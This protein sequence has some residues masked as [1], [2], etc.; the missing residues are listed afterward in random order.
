MGTCP[1]HTMSYISAKVVAANCTCNSLM[2]EVGEGCL[3]NILSSIR[4]WQISFQK[5]KDVIN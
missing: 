5:Y 3:E 1:N 4:L 2:E